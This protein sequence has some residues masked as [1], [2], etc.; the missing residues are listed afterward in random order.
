WL[1]TTRV[2]DY[3]DRVKKDREMYLA[4]AQDFQRL[5]GEFFAIWK[6]WSTLNRPNAAG[7]APE[8]ARWSCLERAAAVE[9]EVEA[10][11][12]KL[13]AEH[14]LSE[15]QINMLG[16]VRQAFKV[17]RRAIGQ[18]Q[19]LNWWSSEAEPYA[20][21]KSLSAAMSVLLTTP[22]RSKKRPS[23]TEAAEVFRQIT[24]NR[25]EDIWMTSAR[26]LGHQPHGS[27]AP[28]RRPPHLRA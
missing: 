7:F 23:A 14:L 21:F 25:H 24:H 17:L 10:L 15:D 19:P 12:A 3:W 4:A 6:T 9:G 5:Y 2:T 26:R 18:G 22:R 11:M 1:V 20:A 16:G 27:T 8:E 13:A 28:D